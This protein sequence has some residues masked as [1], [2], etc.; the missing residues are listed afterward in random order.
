MWEVVAEGETPA[1]RVVAAW[2]VLE[3][4]PAERVPMWA[5]EWLVQGYDGDAL[6]ELAG[7]SGRDTREVRDYLPAALADVGVDAM[8]SEQAAFKVAYDHIATLHLEGRVRWDWAVGQVAGLVIAAG[9]AD[10][11]FEQ[12]L[13]ALWEVDDEF[14]EP[15]S[16]SE[17]ELAQV[18]RQACVRQLRQ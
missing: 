14:D 12:P 15:W 4:L 2:M 17:D 7:L 16:R 3:L 5:A 9:H 18:V 1:P 6:A 11:A 10:V 8:S 13:G